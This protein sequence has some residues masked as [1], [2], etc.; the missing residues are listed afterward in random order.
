MYDRHQTYYARDVTFMANDQERT[1]KKKQSL[2][3]IKP[4]ILFINLHDCYLVTC[5]SWFI[6][7]CMYNSQY[8]TYV[9]H[10]VSGI[11]GI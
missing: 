8:Y 3:V 7:Y 6:Y 4:Q 9:C 10:Q 1:N 5:Y 2:Y 11:T